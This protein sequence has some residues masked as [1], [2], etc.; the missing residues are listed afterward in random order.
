MD[1]ALAATAQTVPPLV[2]PLVTP[3]LWA[4]EPVPRQKQPDVVGR[5]LGVVGDLLSGCHDMNIHE[6]VYRGFS[7]IR[8]LGIQRLKFSANFCERFQATDSGDFGDIRFLK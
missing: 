2:A 7:M 1:W 4:R 3:T 6:L 5:R 8:F